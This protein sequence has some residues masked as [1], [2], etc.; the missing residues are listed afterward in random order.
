MTEN[1]P[2]MNWFMTCCTP[3]SNLFDSTPSLHAA[4]PKTG[5][6][7]GHAGVGLGQVVLV[8]GEER[9]PMRE[10]RFRLRTGVFS[11]TA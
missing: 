7:F 3:A 5:K 1:T 4:L 2:G 6:G 10:G 9:L 8:R 11:G